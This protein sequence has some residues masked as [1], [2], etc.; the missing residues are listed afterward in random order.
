MGLQGTGFEVWWKF[1]GGVG[2]RPAQRQVTGSDDNDHAGAGPVAAMSALLCARMRRC[3]AREAG[4]GGRGRGLEMTMATPSLTTL[5][6][7]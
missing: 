3:R 2:G 7:N 5:G 6:F 4:P 1:D